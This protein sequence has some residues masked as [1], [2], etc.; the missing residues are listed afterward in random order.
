MENGVSSVDS[1]VV[2]ALPVQP[3]PPVQRPVVRPNPPVQFV[4]PVQR[5]PIQ[6]PIRETYGTTFPT[7]KIVTPDWSKFPPR[8]RP[9]TRD[10]VQRMRDDPIQRMRDD[11]NRAAQRARSIQEYNEEVF[12]HP[13]GNPHFGH[14]QGD[15]DSDDDDLY[16]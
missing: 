8:I 10:L 13:Q 16:N 14:P 11:Q 7:P 1:E 15:N 9:H 2:N 4:P 5:P 12:G 6:S 3:I